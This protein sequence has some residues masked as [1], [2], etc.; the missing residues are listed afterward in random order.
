M[1]LT[2]LGLFFAKNKNKISRAAISLVIQ[3]TRVVCPS[4][5]HFPKSASQ[6]EVQADKH[7]FARFNNVL[8]DDRTTRSTL[9]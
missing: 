1:L 7:A 9:V 5:V 6:W 8:I 4:V 2:K 3:S